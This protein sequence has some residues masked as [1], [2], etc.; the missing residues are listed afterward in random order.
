MYD[1][2]GA[3]VT[4][5]LTTEGAYLKLD[6]FSSGNV[7]NL[8]FGVSPYRTGA[9]ISALGVAQVATGNTA[10]AWFEYLMYDGVDALVAKKL[11]EMGVRVTIANVEWYKQDILKE[12]LDVSSDFFTEWATAQE[13]QNQER[14]RLNGLQGKSRLR[15]RQVRTEVFDDYADMEEKE[16]AVKNFPDYDPFKDGEPFKDDVA[17]EQ[18]IQKTQKAVDDLRRIEDKV[19]EIADNQEEQREQDGAYDIGDNEEP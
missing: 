19:D 6:L 3:M 14:E 11:H 7:P 15:K 17:R 13:E 2:Y 10:K 1:S 5:V 18:E 12:R 9:G 8:F 16:A 4:N